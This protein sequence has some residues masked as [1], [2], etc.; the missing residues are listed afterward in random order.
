MSYGLRVGVRVNHRKALPYILERLPPGCKP[1]TSPIVEHLYSVIMGDSD[2][3]SNVRRLNLV[4]WDAARLVRSK[5][6]NQALD[7]LESQVQLN[8][9]EN[10]RR[11]VFVH[12]GVVGW[13]GSAILI[14][15][16]SF[17]GKTTLVEELV[18]AGATYYS[19]E[20]AVLDERGC[21]HPYARPLGIRGSGS[22]QVK[23]PVELIGGKPGSEPLRVGLV[24]STSYRAGSKWRPRKLSAGRGVLELLAHTVCARSQPELA[25]TT[26]P[27]AIASAPVLKSVRGEAKETASAIW[28]IGLRT[29]FRCRNDKPGKNSAELDADTRYA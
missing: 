25:L 10:A 5:D 3:T 24:V 12:A 11:L 4:Y 18:R 20:Y 26:L 16:R 15:G 13:E 19:D 9:A 29:G 22:V 21:V 27:K 1:A 6:W 7:V 8:V 23:V 14:P 17:S 28:R 2:L